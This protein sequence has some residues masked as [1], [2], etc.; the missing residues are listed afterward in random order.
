MLN[1][2]NTLND[3]SKSLLILRLILSVSFLGHGLVSLGFSPSESL[4]LKL[5]TLI[6]F[7][8]FDNQTLLIIHGYFDVIIS[9]LL[10]LNKKLE[11]IIKLIIW[12]LIA[13]SLLAVN[14]YLQQTESIF[15]VAEVFRRLPW[16]CFGVLIL[17]LLKSKE[18]YYLLRIGLA[19]AFL[20][21]GL[22]SLGFFGL[23]QGHIDLALNIIPQDKA[24]DFVFYSGISDTIISLLLFIGLKT[25]WVALIATLWI[26][27]IVYLS[28][29]TA[30]PDALFRTGLLIA[31]F[32][33][34][35]EKRAHMSNLKL[36]IK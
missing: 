4:H 18:S 8:N 23:R 28:Y 21:H 27:F 22:A 25:K 1:N 15:G 30:F 6:N 20:A 24:Q 19:F 32:Y 26:A 5:I 16:I 31:S 34:I 12:Y 7:T 2:S 10:L 9:M 11:W 13:V 14:F 36:S 3:N 29:L 35:I 17:H 33:L